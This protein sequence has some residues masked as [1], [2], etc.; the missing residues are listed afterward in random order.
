MIDNIYVHNH[1]KHGAYVPDHIHLNVTYLLIADEQDTLTH[2]PD[3]NQGV[4]WFDIEDVLNHV[5][6]ERMKIIYKK[7]FKYMKNLHCMI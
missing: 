2:K 7:A 5:S 1:I 6:E 3:E 4:K